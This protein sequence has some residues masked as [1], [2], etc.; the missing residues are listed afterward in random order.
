MVIA[1]GVLV[2]VAPRSALADEP[3]GVKP[4]SLDETSSEAPPPSS[5]AP[6]ESNLAPPSEPET[7]APAP[8]L[9][10]PQ[11]ENVT[12]RRALTVAE[13]RQQSAE[14]V[15]VVDLRRARRENAD[16]GEVMARSQGVAVR[17]AGG[18]GSGTRFSL[19]GL[20][21][22]QIR[23]FL[24]GV[25]LDLAGYPNGISNVPVNLVDRVEVYR[26]VVPVRL[27][28]DALGGAVNLV[29]DERYDARAAASYQVGSFGTRRLTFDGRYRHDATGFVLGAST[30]YDVAQ[31]DYRID[32][33]VPDARGRL[34]PATVRRFHDGY[35]AFG[36]SVEAGFVERP[37]ARRLLV[38][39]F[40][41][42][43][44]K[45]LQ[46]NVVMTVPYG[47]VRYGGSVAGATARYEQPLR[48]DVDLELLASYARRW[49]E[50]EDQATSVYD[51]F[52][53]AIRARRVGGE[54]DGTPRDQLTVQDSLFARGTLTWRFVRGHALRLA[55]SPT[56]TSRTGDERIQADPS[57]RDPL[58]AR[59]TLLTVVTGLEHELTVPVGDIDDA[60]QNI[61]FVKDYVYDA[62]TEEPLPGNV[63]RPLEQS[64]HALGVGDS[65]RYRFTTW[66]L[67]KASYEY[68]RRLPRP[69]EVFGD[70]ILVSPNLRLE[71]EVSHNAN[72]GPRLELRKTRIGDLTVDVNAFLRDSDRL[73]VLLGSDRFFSY[74]NVYRA[75]ALGVE[76]AV[77]WALPKRVFSADATLTYQ[78]V[79]NVSSEGTFGD[80]EGDRIPNRPWL[81]AS[82][83]ARFRLPGLTGPSDA[84]EP[85]YVGRYTHAF[86][87]GWES[88]GLREFKQVV[89]AQ[90][91]HGVGLAWTVTR[92]LARISSVFEVQNVTDA[93]VYDF[94]GVQR[95]GR[96]VFLKV[97]GEL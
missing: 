92:E 16:L 97:T 54:I 45:E 78:D 37:W 56:Y 90:L 43:F 5:A 30:F 93:R 62:R 70:G 32:V 85:F 81:F 44:D 13:Q 28:A 18:L 77:A 69:D 73:V 52:G 31:N 27:G 36:G 87:R 74:Q 1:S 89:D 67:A 3:S 86:F 76:N 96:A 35:F 21:D 19:N 11:T 12:V 68:A 95:P 71:P 8:P 84:L 88:Q 63:F 51:W 9:A 46:H 65:L 7:T 23:F 75:R 17:R 91:T 38:R 40:A 20:Y 24:D 25:P 34:A 66:L 79:R 2:T 47:E 39:G 42:T 15:N 41:S 50:F 60:F 6:S 29:T 80:F 59:K 72:V 64:S 61:A 49:I 22:D 10:T 94:F 33:E 83:S 14:A 48:D 26:G 55:V 58:T 53:R 4:S 57:A 82:W